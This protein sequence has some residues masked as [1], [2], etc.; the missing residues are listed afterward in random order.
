MHHSLNMPALLASPAPGLQ[1]CPA[2]G[3]PLCTWSSKRWLTAVWRRACP[4]TPHWRWRQRRWRAR[5]R[6]APG[7][8]PA[9]AGEVACGVA[10]AAARAGN[11]CCCCLHLKCRLALLRLQMVFSEDETSVLGMVHPGVLKDRCG[12]LPGC[13][14]GT[15]LGA[16]MYVARRH[17]WRSAGKLLLPAR[18]RLPATPPSARGLPPG[19]HH[20]LCRPRDVESISMAAARNGPTTAPP[21]WLPP[22]QGGLASRH[23]HRGPHGAREQRRARRLHPRGHT[24]STALKGAGGLMVRGTTPP[25]PLLGH[26]IT[27]VLLPVLLVLLSHDIS[28]C[29]LPGSIS[30]GPAL[31]LLLSHAL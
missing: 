2:Q 19:R 31:S 16:E 24:C 10:A 13:T 21:C 17:A 6:C 28:R 30:I 12:S 18:A 26:A 8:K 29:Q 23:H 3:Q 1:A 9:G 14:P 15:P 22:L 20:T 11:L 27:P 5:R 25:R 7:T 4:A